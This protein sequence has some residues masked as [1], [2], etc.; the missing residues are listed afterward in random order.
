MYSSASDSDYRARREK[1][2]QEARA[3]YDRSAPFRNPIPVAPAEEPVAK[4]VSTAEPP[5][6]SGGLGGLLSR[7][8]EDDLLLIG[9]LFLLFN[10]N[11]DDDPLI[12]IIFAVLLFS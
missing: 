6:R 3:A 8:R 4:T 10:E 5:A 2:E 1:A 11:K 12:L 9:I 7:I